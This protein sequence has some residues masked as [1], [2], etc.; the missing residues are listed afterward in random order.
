M[1]ALKARQIPKATKALYSQYNSKVLLAL[2]S[3][4]SS[5]HSYFL[6]MYQLSC[7]RVTRCSRQTL[8]WVRAC[9]F[10]SKIDES[11]KNIN[12]LSMGQMF[13]QFEFDEDKPLVPPSADT[14]N[15]TPKEIIDDSPFLEEELG[16]FFF[17]IP[18]N[19]V[20]NR[21]ACWNKK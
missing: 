18:N 2:F 4:R 9:L 14:H 20:L 16:N 19:F 21:S 8:F 6:D 12:Q 17:K 3:C 13:R 7:L 5:C 1:F 10:S 15:D 11:S